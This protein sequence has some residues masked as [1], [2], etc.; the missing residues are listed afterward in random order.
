MPRILGRYAIY[1][2]IA[3]GGMAT[4]HYGR[5]MG[6]EGFSRTVAVKCLHAQF[7]QDPDFVQMF[8]D[9]ARMAARIR[10]PNVVATLDVVTQDGEVFLVMDYVH[11]DSLGQILRQLYRRGERVPFPIALRIGTDILQGLHAAHEARDEQG[12]P[13]NM[14]HRDVSPQNVLLGIDGVARL[15]DF[16]VAKAAGRAHSTRDGRIKGKI[17]YMAPEQ[18]RSQPVTRQADIHAF[19]IVLW[20]MITGQKLFTGDSEAEVFAAV[21]RHDIPSLSRLVAVPPALAAVVARGVDPNLAARY[22]TARE[23]CIDLGRCG[24]VAQTMEVADWAH[25]QLAETLR[26]RDRMVSVIERESAVPSERSVVASGVMPAKNWG[27][28]RD[29]RIEE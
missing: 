24:P 14:V 8:L 19:A 11:G 10:H 21:M 1:D 29:V 28:S 5:L 22:A 23:M 16:G 18:L 6:P 26:P 2:A 3:A 4:V 25:A 7:A 20:E 15:V 27:P 9:E 12:T 17:G 13:L